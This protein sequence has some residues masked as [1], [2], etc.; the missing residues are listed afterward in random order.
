LIEADT[1]G[2]KAENI[3]PEYEPNCKKMKEKEYG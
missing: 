2:S 1:F 3:L